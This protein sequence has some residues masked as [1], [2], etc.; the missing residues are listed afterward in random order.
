M[1]AVD[2]CPDVQ[3]FAKEGP[4]RHLESTVK[5]RLLEGYLSTGKME[6]VAAVLRSIVDGPNWKLVREAADHLDK[7]TPEAPI[8]RG[9]EAAT[10]DPAGF[11]RL[12]DSH[13]EKDGRGRG[14][15]RLDGEE[16]DMLDLH[17]RLPMDEDPLLAERLGLQ[18][19]P[20]RK[21][22]ILLS[23][24]AAALWAR[25]EGPALNERGLGPCPPRAS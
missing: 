8:T 23:A 17:D 7:M 4:S 11:A 12:I 18:G 5:G 1:K 16:W 2:T 24:V 21:Q 6:E 20:E 9:G 19:E 10:P 13:T 25:G 15:L 14:V 22:C 3:G